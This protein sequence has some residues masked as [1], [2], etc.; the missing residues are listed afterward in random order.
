MFIKAKMEETQRIQ[1][2]KA[3][4]LSNWQSVELGETVDTSARFMVIQG[5]NYIYSKILQMINETKSQLST[6]STVQ[7]LH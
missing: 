4:I 7:G 2:N 1:K 5:R 3:E 6:V